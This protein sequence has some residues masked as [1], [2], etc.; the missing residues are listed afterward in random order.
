MYRT[1]SVFPVVL[2]TLAAGCASRPDVLAM[3]EPRPARDAQAVALLLDVPDRPFE[4]VAII[5]SSH[6]NFLRDVDDLK[7]EVRR[8]AA[9]VGAD[10]VI[11]S[12]SSQEGSGGTGLTSDGQVVVVGGDSG[13]LR[14]VGR[15][16][17]YTDG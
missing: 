7:A 13:S 5:R 11:L 15:A 6:R 3:E 9:E 2:I 17:V 8:A 12:L 4:T 1:R 16:I 10:A 14:V